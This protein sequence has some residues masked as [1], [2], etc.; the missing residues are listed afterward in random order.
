M[1][2]IRIAP[3]QALLLW[4]TNYSGFRLNSTLTLGAPVPWRILT[5][6]VT[7]NGTLYNVSVTTTNPAQLFRLR[8]P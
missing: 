8:K 2:V 3:A 1:T 6:A 5:N 4:P 7:T